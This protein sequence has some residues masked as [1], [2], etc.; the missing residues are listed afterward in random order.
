MP[1]VPKNFVDQQGPVVNSAWLNPIDY[2][3]NSVFAGA[4]TNPAARTALCA[5]LPLEIANGGTAGRTA[6]AAL[7]ALGGI[8]QAALTAATTQAVLGATIWPQTAAELA[9][10]VTP[11]NYFWPPGVVDRYGT[12]TT[13]GTTDMTAAFSAALSQQQASGGSPIQLR[14]ETYAVSSNAIKLQSNSIPLVVFGVPRQSCIV[15]LAPANTPTI[16]LID[17]FTFDIR[18]IV[19]AGRSGFPNIGI[20][21]TSAT[22]GQRTGFGVIKDV[23]LLTNGAGIHIAGCNDITIGNWTYWPNGAGS[24]PGAATFDTNAQTAGLLA[25]TNGISSY[26]PGQSNSIYMR[27]IQVGEVN[28]I[29]NGG[30]GIKIDGSANSSGPVGAQTSNADWRIEGYD[31]GT[32]QR[33]LWVRNTYVSKYS[34]IYTG[35]EIRFDQTSARSTLDMLYGSTVVVDGTQSLGGCDQLTFINC[36]AESITA[37]SANSCST[38]I[39]CDWFT[40]D[41]DS[42]LGKET[43]NHRSASVRQ[44]DILGTLGL[45]LGQSATTPSIGTG[46][47]IVTSQLTVVKVTNSGACTGVILAK[48]AVPQDSPSGAMIVLMNQGSGSITFAASGT[49]FVSGGTG[50]VIAAGAKMI[51][52]FDSTTGLWY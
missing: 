38:H 8:N 5:D 34:S 39:N 50:V 27:G 47:T 20:D 46:S 35:G 43:I 21:L 24:L 45:S 36:F 3:A 31:S 30:C 14:P 40:S 15:N 37:D 49:S 16:Q 4:T 33:A 52:V 19:F 44:G 6:A 1:F 22:G 51:F 13:P 9:A 18:G 29:A 11:V 12:N 7:S 48:P 32:S 23:D 10:S 41:S 42:S 2:L 17:K 26:N 28:S 25:D